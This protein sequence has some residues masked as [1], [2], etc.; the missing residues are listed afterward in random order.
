[1]GQTKERRNKMKEIRHKT[2][3]E[4]IHTTGADLREANLRGAD[5][6]RADLYGADLCRANLRGAKIK[7]SQKE[8]ILKAIHLTIKE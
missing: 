5:L 8:T 6:C 4:I 7:K 1:M 3:R 2:T